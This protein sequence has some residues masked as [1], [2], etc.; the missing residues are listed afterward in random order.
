MPLEDQEFLDF[1]EAEAG[2]DGARET[3]DVTQAMHA[4]EEAD[5]FFPA[6]SGHGASLVFPSVRE[7]MARFGQLEH[8]HQVA[9]FIPPLTGAS[10][11]VDLAGV[12]SHGL[13]STEHEMQ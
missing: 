2:I 8:E 9:P 13:P 11:N 6:S 5:M 10:G 3:Y 12:P 1:L 4:F 7:N